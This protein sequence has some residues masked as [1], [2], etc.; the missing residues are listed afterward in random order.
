M[1]IPFG[2]ISFD[3]TTFVYNFG[4]PYVISFS[5][6]EVRDIN[7]NPFYIFFWLK[8]FFFGGGQFFLH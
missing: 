8:C 2:F 7:I 5:K 1:C 4:Y 6:F 3:V